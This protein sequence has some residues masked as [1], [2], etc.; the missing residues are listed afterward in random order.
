[1]RRILLL[2]VLLLTPAWCDDLLE[3]PGGLVERVELPGGPTVLLQPLPEQPSISL[4]MVVPAGARFDQEGR[5]GEAHLLEHLLFR[6]TRSNPGGRLLVNL[7]QVGARAGART[8]PDYL[9]F[10]ETLPSQYLDF[11]LQNQ[12]DRLKELFADNDDLAREKALALWEMAARESSG[13]RLLR[14]L[15]EGLWPSLGP[16]T[17]KPKELKEITL[18]QLRERYQKT[19]RREEAV[20]A[21]VGGFST[22]DVRRKLRALFPPPVET[23]QPRPEQKLPEPAPNGLQVDELGPPALEMV[24]PLPQTSPTLAQ[25]YL[26]DAALTGGS[27]S[28]LAHSGRTLNTEYSPELSFYRLRMTP[29]E[30]Q[31][32]PQLEQLV[33]NELKRVT[34]SP[35]PPDQMVTARDRALAR[36]YRELE[37][38]GRRATLMA[39]RQAQG[40]LD[41]MSSLPEEIRQAASAQLLEIAQTVLSPDQAAI[42]RVIGG[43]GDPSP[44]SIEAETGLGPGPVAQ[45]D[46]RV[47][48]KPAPPPPTFVRHELE[49][50]LT[51][52]IQTVNDLPTVT[53]RGYLRGGTLLDPRD[54]PGLTYLA[55][56][57]LG[58]GTQK[59]PGQSFAW[60]LQDLGAELTFEPDRQVIA[61]KGWTRSE[62]FPAFMEMLV[63]A[64]RN[65]DP[66]EEAIYRTRL[67]AIEEDRSELASLSRRAS[68]ELRQ[69]IYP[70]GHPYG[71]PLTGAP[72]VIRQ[73]SKAEV[74]AHLNRSVRPDRLVLV[75]SG[76]V[77]TEE[78]LRR[79]RPGLTAWYVQQ[80]APLVT[81]PPAPMGEGETVKF[82]TKAK[83]SLVVM[84]H[85][86]PSRR[87][88]D[89]YA[90]N[91]L[92]QV[93]GGNRVTS[94]LALRLRDH[95]GLASRVASQF[96]PS[97]GPGPWAISLRVKPGSEEKAVDL[98]R[99]EIAHLRQTP[100]SDAELEQAVRA[101][102]GRLQ[103]SQ[104]SAVGR[105]ELLA[106]LEFYRLSDTYSEGFS[107][108]YRR[109]TG[110]QL[111]QT[112]K[113]RFYPDK[114]VTVILG[115]SEVK[116]GG[117][118]QVKDEA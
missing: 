77:T 116:S 62:H 42:G 89:F 48:E 108:I 5:A 46:W 92:N 7:E 74:L 53:V 39:V 22:R 80:T 56:S 110:Q 15:M 13:S 113:K 61:I 65:P 2:L 86:G 35:L 25:L 32:V 69:R 72:E 18:A 11:S 70:E 118:S 117:N 31:T 99:D 59:R 88:S 73:A 6:A 34:S 47:E 105:A 40:R 14:K 93:L 63:D 21:I 111:L 83:E 84:G 45:A 57:L 27:G 103:V 28:Q 97:A 75:F 12:G 55:G 51:V 33:R 91:L 37:Y 104:G 82:K 95:E 30:N 64:L 44:G 98:V 19:V 76:D 58:Q 107:G 38:P 54:R 16:A 79:I 26:L 24:F 17:G 90:F 60:D 87:D 115:R 50:G 106:N 43:S 109:I 8:S 41:E 112:A 68:R 20:I 52:L 49:N 81:V 67:K 29:A 102:E 94:R 78:V 4:A 1:M 71:L 66:D 114:L 23:P 96:L 100:P 9:L 3:M 85:V 36:F 10:W 101:L